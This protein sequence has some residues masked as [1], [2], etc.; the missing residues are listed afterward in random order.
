MELKDGA[1]YLNMGCKLLV[2][3]TLI[4]LGQ[5]MVSLTPLH[6]IN[7]QKLKVKVELKQGSLMTCYTHAQDLLQYSKSNGFTKK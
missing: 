4:D 6:R 2:K 5:K 7:I 1:R 3:Q